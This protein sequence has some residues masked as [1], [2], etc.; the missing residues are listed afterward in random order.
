MVEFANIVVVLASGV[1]YFGLVVSG[2]VYFGLVASG[3]EVC[4]AKMCEVVDSGEDSMVCVVV[5]LG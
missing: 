5:P 1:V 2:V 4:N 3:E